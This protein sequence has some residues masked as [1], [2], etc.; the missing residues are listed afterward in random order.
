MKIKNVE[1]RDSRFMIH[2]FVIR[3]EHS[4]MSDTRDCVA[5]HRAV[6]LLDRFVLVS[7]A[8]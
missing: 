5:Q 1:N 4:V 6:E 3:E 7:W 8:P 2:D